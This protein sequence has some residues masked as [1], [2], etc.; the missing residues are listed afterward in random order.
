MP[1]FIW[2]SNA[3]YIRDYL[4]ELTFSNGLSRKVDLKHLIDRRLAIF[5][6]LLNLET[7]KNFKLND[8]TISWLDGKID[9]A[10]ERLYELATL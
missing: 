9:I 7:F 5:H 6:P 1:E 2:I 4:L 10:P 8:W 3:K